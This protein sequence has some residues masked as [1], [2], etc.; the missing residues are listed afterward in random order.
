MHPYIPYIIT[1]IKAAHR[2]EIPNKSSEVSEI[3]NH[4]DEMERWAGR[5]CSET[6]IW[7]LLRP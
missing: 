6:H 7:V 4:L 3:E 1:D 5:G 2:V